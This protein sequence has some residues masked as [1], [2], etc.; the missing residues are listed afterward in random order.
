[1]GGLVKGDGDDQRQYPNRHVIEGDVQTDV[2]TGWI[3]ATLS[4]IE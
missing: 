4:R 2:L 3:D 1:V